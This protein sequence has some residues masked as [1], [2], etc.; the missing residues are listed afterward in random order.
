MGDDL[1][2]EVADEA[3]SCLSVLLGL[4]PIV[5]KLLLSVFLALVS[6][7]LVLYFGRENRRCRKDLI[8][9]LELLSGAL[10]IRVSY[11]FAVDFCHIRESVNYK[12]SEEHGVGHLIIFDRDGG[13]RLESLELRDLDEA[14][15]VV[16]REYQSLQVDKPLQL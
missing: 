9:V 3:L 5:L 1:L 16:I 6:V 14:I 2:G 11:C 15:N 12:C 8:E 7:G 13:K 10:L 4:K